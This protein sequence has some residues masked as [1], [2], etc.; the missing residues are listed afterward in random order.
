MTDN[1]PDAMKG[2]TVTLPGR[3][4][5]ARVNRRARSRI[6]G[7]RAN[8]PPDL[9]PPLPGEKRFRIS[10]DSKIGRATVR[11]W[12]RRR[13]F[14]VADKGKIPGRVV[15][16]FLQENDIY[17]VKEFYVK[18]KGPGGK[19]YVSKLYQLYQGKYIV[20]VKNGQR[21]TDDLD[22]IKRAMGADLFRMLKQVQP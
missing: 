9:E 7:E 11:R 18:A 6:P 10:V 21:E 14:D 16:E 22:Y 19:E 12:A 13:G 1:I 2:L 17:M 4:D 8:T 15:T 3:H 5:R 20:F